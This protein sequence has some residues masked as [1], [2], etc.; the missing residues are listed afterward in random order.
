MYI[1]YIRTSIF[2][3]KKTV[4][5]QKKSFY[6]FVLETIEKVSFWFRRLFL[7][8]TYIILF[9]LQSDEQERDGQLPLD[10]QT[11]PIGWTVPPVERRPGGVQHGLRL[12][13]AGQ[14]KNKGSK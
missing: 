1:L 14:A 4:V 12:S 9:F 8:L 5:R 7:L 3:L 11:G 2:Y 13:R 10:D 6:F